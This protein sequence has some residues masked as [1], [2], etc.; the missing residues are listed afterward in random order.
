MT[1]SNDGFYLHEIEKDPSLLQKMLHQAKSIK[2]LIDLKR[3]KVKTISEKVGLK[4]NLE[5]T[6]HGLESKIKQ[7]F[8]SKLPELVIHKDHYI[9][10]IEVVASSSASDDI[11]LLHK[12]LAEVRSR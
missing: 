1:K 7:V 12:L 11:A 4:D 9:Q 8:S 3:F 6:S 10:H 2:Q 5:V